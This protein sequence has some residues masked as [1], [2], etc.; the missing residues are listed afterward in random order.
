[1]RTYEDWIAKNRALVH[2][3]SGGRMGYVWLL[4]TGPHGYQAF[5]REFYAQLDKQGVII[6][7]RYNQGGLLGEYI[8]DTIKRVLFG[9]VAARDGAAFPR[10]SPR[11]P[12]RRSC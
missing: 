9:Y 1:M 2:E 12:D 3:R 11:C 8:I 7:V 5:N 4:N 10:H 6:D